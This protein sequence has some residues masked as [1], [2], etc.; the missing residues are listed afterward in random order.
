M[1]WFT[2]YGTQHTGAVHDANEAKGT[3][4]T[5]TYELKC[6]R[7]G[8][9]GQSE[10]WRF[11][12]LVCFDCGGSGRSGRMTAD[13]L[14]S[15]E[16]LAKLNAA[17]DKRNAA[18]LV[19]QLAAQ[20]V[21]NAARRTKWLEFRNAHQALVEALA[22]HGELAQEG[23]EGA[24]AFLADMYA[25]LEEWGSLTDGQVSA[26]QKTIARLAERAMAR[27][28]S[29][30]VGTVGKR[31][32]LTLTVE[33]IIK[34]QS[35]DAFSPGGRYHQWALPSIFLCRDDNGNRIVYKGASDFG[36]KGDTVRVKATVEGHDTYK[37]E[38]QTK[39][40]RPK[41]LGTL[42]VETGKFMI[43]DSST[44]SMVEAA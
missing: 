44:M 36:A 3:A 11:T 30:F 5:A 8:G 31:L 42:D 40:A 7:C 10:K 35:Q 21:K 27:A 17:E 19:K 32:V 41:L 28:T 4:R 43:Y 26:A 18:Q 23:L 24:D 16:R 38:N 39:I 14:Y 15:A 9:A 29:Q 20:E 1:E 6:S 2:R 12:G 22:W 37:D 13:K 34:L 33:H 25:K